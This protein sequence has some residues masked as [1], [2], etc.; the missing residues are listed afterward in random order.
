MGA[1]HIR[2]LLLI[3]PLFIVAVLSGCKNDIEHI[4]AKWL[5]E[6]SL[7]PHFTNEQKQGD[8]SETKVFTDAETFK[9]LAEA[10]NTSKKL[11]GD[12]DWEPDFDMKLL[13]GDGYTEEYYIALGEEYGYRGMFTTAKNSSQ[14]YVIPVKKSDQLRTLLLGASSS[15]EA[16]QVKPV[17]SKV[18][19]TD[20]M[21]LSHNELSSVTHG[22]QS[23]DLQFLEGQ[24][25]EDWITPSPFMGR[26]WSGRFALVLNDEQGNQ[27]N[28]F[29][30]SDHFADKTLLFND[31]FQIQFE[32]YNGDGDPDFTIGQYGT[33]NGNFYKL[34]TLRNNNV[35]EELAIKP[36]SELFISGSDKYSTRLEKIDEFRFNTTYYDNVEGKQKKDIFQWDGNVF[37]MV[38]K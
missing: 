10:M 12:I 19:V 22:L 8:S 15:T 2:R 27:M 35:I 5:S 13:Y 34:F 3:V 33:S 7:N 37:Q 26:S 23:L 30:I 38:N 14:G 25:D 6:V 21:T 1:V 36:T 24:Y 17:K 18:T 31:F 29:P 9:L 4:N 16:E 32:D 20:K 28:A 11:S